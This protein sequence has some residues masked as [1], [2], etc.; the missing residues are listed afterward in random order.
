MLSA[1]RRAG[2]VTTRHRLRK[3]TVKQNSNACLQR[4]LLTARRSFEKDSVG[5][6]SLW[7]TALQAHSTQPTR[8]MD[9][10]S[11]QPYTT[12]KNYYS[13]LWNLKPVNSL[14]EGAANVR[15][16]QTLSTQ[17]YSTRTTHYR[18]PNRRDKNPGCVGT[19]IDG[20]VSFSA[21]AD[22]TPKSE[23]TKPSPRI[24]TTKIPTPPSGPVEAN[25]LTELSNTS[26]RS[27]VNK[28]TDAFISVMKTVL[29]F[30]FSIPGNV[31]YYL[32]HPTERRERIAG[33]KQAA[34]DEAHHYWMGTKVRKTI[35]INPNFRAPSHRS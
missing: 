28:G 11:C 15:S 27:I 21:G 18:L 3:T 14:P 7:T 30:I 33:L 32:T 35:E 17:A 5:R 16:F 20:T 13:S 24:G 31:F 22:E 29:S 6:A 19:R 9:R 25:P 23:K 8:I 2:V 26:T 1:A 12:E 34:K 4:D 10:F